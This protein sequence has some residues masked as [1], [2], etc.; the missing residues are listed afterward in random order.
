[1]V[2]EKEVCFVVDGCSCISSCSL[3][4]DVEKWKEKEALLPFFLR[5]GFIQISIHNNTI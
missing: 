3:L 1:M 5:E 4:F 2:I